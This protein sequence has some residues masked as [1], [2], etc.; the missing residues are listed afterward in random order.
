MRV[1]HPAPSTLTCRGSRREPPSTCTPTV[2]ALARPW[3]SPTAAARLEAASAT[4][5]ARRWRSA[6]QPPWS[7]RVADG[8]PPPHLEA[9]TRLRPLLGAP[10]ACAGDSPA[11]R[12]TARSHAADPRAADPPARSPWR[13]A[14]A[15]PV[16]VDGG[17]P[18][19]PHPAP[20]K[21]EEGSR[22]SGGGGVG[23]G[24]MG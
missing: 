7:P 11:R 4:H 14:A 12:S 15:A 5:P 20:L 10:V 9:G 3:K 13:S 6:P 8:W 19:S 1:S 17:T 22:G 16:G 2:V 24:G 23:W 18:R 21:R